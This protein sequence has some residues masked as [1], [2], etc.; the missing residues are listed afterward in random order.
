M[1]ILHE[2]QV[3]SDLQGPIQLAGLGFVS[4]FALHLL[5]WRTRL[6]R[7]LAYGWLFTL[8]TVGGLAAP[9]LWP[10]VGVGPWT[11]HAVPAAALYLL[12]SMLYLHFYSGLVRSLSVRIL[13]ELAAVD[14]HH[15]DADELARR[16]P[17]G[18]ILDRRLDALEAT[19]WIERR[20]EAYRN[21]PRGHRWAR[22][23]RGLARLYRR[24]VTG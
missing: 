9:A 17:L 2:L 1:E 24:D 11:L 5:V 8:L 4:F 13:G 6:R 7:G 19:G 23:L 3:L 16:Y 14:D 20:D 12:L 18:E 22:W 15:L 21:R 10:L